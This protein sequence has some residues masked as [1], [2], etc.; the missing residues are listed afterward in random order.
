MTE[1]KV[2][3]CLNCLNF[4]KRTYLNFFYLISNKISKLKCLRYLNI[5]KY[6]ITS[7]PFNLFISD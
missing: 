6:F 5:P 4:F 2:T 3:H 7:S 1:I